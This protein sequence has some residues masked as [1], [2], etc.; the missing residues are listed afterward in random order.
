MNKFGRF[1][2]N[3]IEKTLNLYDK[4]YDKYVSRFDKERPECLNIDPEMTAV[5]DK[6]CNTAINRIQLGTA[7]GSP[8]LPYKL[9]E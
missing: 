1:C 4:F 3:T 6:I 8:P 2:Y 7:D 9:P 5:I